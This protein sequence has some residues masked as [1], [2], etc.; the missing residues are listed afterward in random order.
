MFLSPSDNPEPDLEQAGQATVLLSKGLI[1]HPKASWNCPQTSVAFNQSCSYSVWGK[2]P[3]WPWQSAPRPCSGHQVLKKSV[4]CLIW[5]RFP[6]LS[7]FYK[8]GAGN[9]D[10]ALRATQGKAR[11]KTK[12]S[13]KVL[14]TPKISHLRT[15]VFHLHSVGRRWNLEACGRKAALIYFVRSQKHSAEVFKHALE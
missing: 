14:I 5:P 3:E 10:F 12:S 6:K 8:T 1:A 4:G 7:H 13:H 15:L 2:Q 11:W 9:I